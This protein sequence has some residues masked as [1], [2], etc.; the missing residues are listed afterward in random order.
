MLERTFAS[1]EQNANTGD[2]QIAED[3]ENVAD[4]SV[5]VEIGLG[6]HV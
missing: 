2:E 1:H 4:G 3:D 6:K 5:Q